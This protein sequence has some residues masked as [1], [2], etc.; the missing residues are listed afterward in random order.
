[1]YKINNAKD[2][3]IADYLTYLSNEVLTARYRHRTRTFQSSLI[4]SESALI[5][6]VGDKEFY[7]IMSID[8]SDATCPFQTANNSFEW[9]G[10][11]LV[12]VIKESYFNIATQYT[13]WLLPM[14]I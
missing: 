6:Y 5:L 3:E 11:P 8:R 1:M 9:L 4:D 10:C 14:S 12:R 2:Q 7:A 13:R